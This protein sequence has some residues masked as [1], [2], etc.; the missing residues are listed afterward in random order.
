MN[1]SRR[2]FLG[3]ALGAALVSTAPAALLWH[4]S[5][6]NVNYMLSEIDRI[7]DEAYEKPEFWYN[8]AEIA[9][10]KAHGGWPD[11]SRIS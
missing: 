10:Y 4:Q 7:C 9:A 5:E 1:H 2:G 3:I 8:P 11:V 6:W